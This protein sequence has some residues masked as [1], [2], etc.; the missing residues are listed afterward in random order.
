MLGTHSNISKLGVSGLTK[1]RTFNKIFNGL[2]G[3][4]LGIPAYSYWQVRVKW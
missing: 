3:K 4:W 1:V 2:I